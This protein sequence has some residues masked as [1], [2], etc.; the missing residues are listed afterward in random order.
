MES[1][2][3][4]APQKCIRAARGQHVSHVTGQS[5][6]WPTLSLR[7]ACLGQVGVLLSAFSVGFEVLHVRSIT[8]A[9]VMTHAAHS[10]VKDLSMA[11]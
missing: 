10:Q 4:S 3:S 11:A 6:K 9:S 5:W 2:L 1:I 8:C 7:S